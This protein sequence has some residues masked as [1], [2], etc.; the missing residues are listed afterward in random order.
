MFVEN[1]RRF[2][3]KKQQMTNSTNTKLA[4]N[5]DDYN[6]FEHRVID[7]P[8]ST[9]GSLAHLL[10]SFLGTGVLAMAAAIGNAGLLF[11]AIGTVVVGILCAH[12]VHI[13]VSTSHKICRVSRTPVLGFAET[14]EKVFQY[15]PDWAKRHATTAKNFVDYGIMATYYSAGCV[16][17]V[18]VANTFHEVCNYLFAINLNIRIY[19]L[20]IMI[21]IL[22]IGQIRVLKFLVPFSATANVF[23]LVTFA[24]V[25][26]Y[27]FKEPL[28]FSDLPLVVSWT[29]WPLFFATVIFAMEGIGAVMPVENAMKKPQQFLGCPGVLNTSMTVTIILYAL[30]GILGYARYRGEIR[31]SITLNLPTTEVTALIG[32]VLIGL[33]I[34][35]TFGLQFFVPMEI[36][37]KKLEP[38]IAKDKRNVYEI[39]IRTGIMVLMAAIAILVPNLE[40]FISL[41]GAIFFSS[42]G[43]FVPA[44]VETIF[45]HSYGG[46]G[47]F[48]WKLYKNIFIMIFA[49]LALISGGFASIL[50]IIHGYSNEGGDKKS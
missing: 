30:V 1:Q 26:Y 12:C 7:K 35:F 4:D 14:A 38:K 2:S 9:M 18:F 25:L 16:Y 21:P 34:M 23:I 24:I 10:K 39:A 50:E 47:R 33:A 42:L 41:V 43:L 36:L 27:I 29:K 3:P 8:N 5:E 11:G 37:M 31:G 19:I 17:I 32:Q 13:L 6:P 22:F 49:M 28:V 20:I 15:G 46:H 48:N 44:F 45:L 40:P